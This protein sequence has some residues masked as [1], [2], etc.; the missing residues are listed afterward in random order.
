MAPFQMERMSIQVV[1]FSLAKASTALVS[2]N[3][4]VQPRISTSNGSPFAFV[5]VHSRF[6]L[7]DG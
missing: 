1:S 4:S 2:R 5:G 7:P 6:G 3:N